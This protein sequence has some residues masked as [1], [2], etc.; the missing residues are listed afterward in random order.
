MENQLIGMLEGIIRP[1]VVKAVM[2]G[3]A[4]L[5][6]NRTQITPD[7]NRYEIGVKVACEELGAKCQ[8]VYQNIHKI[9]HKKIHGKLY[10]KREELQEYIKNEGKK[11]RHEAKLSP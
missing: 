10:F 9:P 3:L 6:L 2:D 5:G 1:I 4:D 11:L 8:T 7:S